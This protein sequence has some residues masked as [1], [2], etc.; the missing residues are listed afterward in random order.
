MCGNRNFY[1]AKWTTVKLYTDNIIE[2][3]TS[4]KRAFHCFHGC[5]LHP[6]YILGSASCSSGICSFRFNNVGHVIN[7]LK[8]TCSL[9]FHKPANIFGQIAATFLIRNFE[10]LALVYPIESIFKI[11][12]V[13]V[14]DFEL[15]LASFWAT[16]G[17]SNSGHFI[18]QPIRI[19]YLG[20]VTWMDQSACRIS[21][22]L[23][24]HVK[25]SR[26]VPGSER[27]VYCE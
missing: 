26:K 17:S 12:T 10:L 22:Q 25:P 24:L 3:H 6:F 23:V 18:T 1:I 16:H 5:H 2:E 7:V 20:H 27:K 15:H 4:V 21:W 13:C 19:E 9:P 11:N 14:S 8:I